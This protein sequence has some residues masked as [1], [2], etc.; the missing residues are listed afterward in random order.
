MRLVEV[1][2]SNVGDLG[3]VDV[4][5]VQKVIA[6]YFLHNFVDV[7]RKEDTFAL[8]EGVRLDDIGRFIPTVCIMCEMVP[9][10]SELAREDPR[11]R[12]EIKLLREDFAH[13]HQ[14]LR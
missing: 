13:S 3:R 9:Q 1:L 12:E 8:A 11:F 6:L 5:L 2:L 7:S 14:V 4:V 10:I